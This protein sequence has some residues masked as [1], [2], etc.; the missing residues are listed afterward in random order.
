MNEQ[1]TNIDDISLQ[2]LNSSQN[3]STI[4]TVVNKRKRNENFSHLFV[5]ENSNA[6]NSS[7]ES[8]ISDYIIRKNKNKKRI[9]KRKTQS[10]GDTGGDHNSKRSK[11]LTKKDNVD[12][13]SV[14]VQQQV[15]LD[16]LHEQNNKDAQ[17]VQQEQPFLNL[18]NNDKNISI[19]KTTL[20]L[21]L[22]AG[23]TSNN[24]TSGVARIK[25]NIIDRKWDVVEGVSTYLFNKWL[26]HLFIV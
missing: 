24:S 11:K 4:A 6:D 18:M 3:S 8:T 20:P 9:I 7:G 13:E 17:Q 21:T 26:S 14:N 23:T 2:S 22:C 19:E 15:H 25:A 16:E 10:E 5:E 1:I 12:K